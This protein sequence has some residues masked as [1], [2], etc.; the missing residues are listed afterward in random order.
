MSI[1]S[2]DCDRHSSIHRH[3]YSFRFDSVPLPNFS[4]QEFAR[5]LE[6]AEGS[7]EMYREFTMDDSNIFSWTCVLLPV[8]LIVHRWQRSQSL[9][10]DHNAHRFLQKSAPYNKGAYRLTIKFPEN[11]PFKPPKVCIIPPPSSP[12]SL[13]GLTFQ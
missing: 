10:F 13:L 8:C 3:T 7:L 1:S 12:A 9:L 6:E 5:V 11:Y 2:V 4:P